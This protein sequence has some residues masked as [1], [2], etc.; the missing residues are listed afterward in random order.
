MV[1]GRSWSGE[2]PSG[3]GG[4]LLA[5]RGAR[6][7]VGLAALSGVM[8]AG[9]SLFNKVG[10]GTMPVLLWAFLVQAVDAVLL[11]IVLGVRGG[12]VWPRPGAPRW[13][14]L[15]IGALML[16]AYLAIL[17]ALT[18]A[19]VSYVVAGREVSIVV[20]ALAGALLLHERHSSRRIAGAAVIFL[21]LVVLAFSR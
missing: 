14:A 21:G 3:R 7:A 9:Y 13:R 15:A 20:T 4:T 16:G 5:L 10:V 19:P 11:S 12:V 1:T 8:I 17:S 2:R 6:G 18:L